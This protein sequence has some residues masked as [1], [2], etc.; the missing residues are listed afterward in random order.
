VVDTV[1]S[2]GTVVLTTACDQMRY[3]ASWREYQQ[4]VPTFVMNVPSTWQT[5]ASR[6]LYLEEL[7]RLSRFLVAQGG[8]SPSREELADVMRQFEDARTRLRQVRA[9]LTSR[10]FAAALLAVREDA[11]PGAWLPAE[12]HF[13]ASAVESRGD[14]ADGDGIPLALAGGPLSESDYECSTGS[15]KLAAESS[16]M[17]PSGASGLCPGRLLERLDR[18]PLAELADAYFGSIPDVFRRPNSALYE[19]LSRELSDRHARGLIVRRY[20]W[21]DLWHAEVAPLKAWSPVPVLDL[22][23]ADSE[24]SSAGR[25]RGRIEAFLEMLR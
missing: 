9:S 5:E 17:R 14:W 8:R 18:D 23:A 4:H 13:P 15:S 3:A 19:Y 7:L 2:A 12:H 22:E 25:T 6:S 16:W 1:A 11:S 10:E 24:A 20:L 21:C